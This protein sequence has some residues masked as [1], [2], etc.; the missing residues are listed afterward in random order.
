MDDY[1]CRELIEIDLDVKTSH[2]VIERLSKLLYKGGY[3]KDSFLDAVIEREKQYATGIPLDPVGIAIPHTD[4]IH[5]KKRAVA[6]GILAN[7]I[8][9][10]TMG[11]D[12]EID[13]E[14]Y[15]VL[16]MLQV[17]VKGGPKDLVR[18]RIVG[19][20]GEEAELS[21]WNFPSINIYA[22]TCGQAP[23]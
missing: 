15:S 7:P 23:S 8:K 14:G 5:V 10:G 1:F 6:V 17:D 11:G 13:V 2:E 4:G 20:F 18:I 12:G 9:F 22:I 16:D 21:I 3:V 19:E